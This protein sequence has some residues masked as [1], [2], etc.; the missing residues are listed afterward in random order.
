MHYPRCQECKKHAEGWKTEAWGIKD[1][2]H[3]GKRL[4][5][6]AEYDYGA[7]TKTIFLPETI[8]F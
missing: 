1:T 7:I 5:M 4:Q 8:C 3:G 2:N 6:L